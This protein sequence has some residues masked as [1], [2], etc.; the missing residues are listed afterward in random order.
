MKMALNIIGVLSGILSLC[1]GMAIKGCSLGSY[2]TDYSYGGDAYTGIQNAAA[3]AANNIQ[4]TNYILVQ[5]FSYLLIVLGL[6]LVAY[7][8]LNFLNCLREKKEAKIVETPLP[9]GPVEKKESEVALLEENTEE[10]VA[11][12]TPDTVK[13]EV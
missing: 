9:E 3:Q 12:E 1:F 7:F 11:E 4:E 10:V 2:E 13:E 6:A 5:G 8:G